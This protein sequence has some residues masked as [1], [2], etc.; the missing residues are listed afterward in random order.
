[1]KKLLK[2]VKNDDDSVRV[3][4]FLHKCEN[5]ENRTGLTALYQMLGITI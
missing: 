2:L 3:T 5:A 1:M 4:E